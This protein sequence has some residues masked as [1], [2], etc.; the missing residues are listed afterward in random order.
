M[1]VMCE[2]NERYDCKTARWIQKINAMHVNPKHKW[3]MKKKFSQRLGNWKFFIFNRSSIDRLLIESGRFKQKNLIAISIGRETGLIDQKSGK[4]KFLK[5][6]AILC[7]NS[8]KHSISWMKCISI[9]LKVFQKHLNSTQIF[10][11][12]DF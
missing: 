4:I 11:R 7:R 9:R 10:Q 6:R 5:N 1:H 8:S 12:Q 3:C 2:N